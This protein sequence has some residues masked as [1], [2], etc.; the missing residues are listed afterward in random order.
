ME[1][2]LEDVVNIYEGKYK[3]CAEAIQRRHKDIL[4]NIW[5]NGRDLATIRDE[6]KPLKLWCLWQEQVLGMN[7]KTVNN[8]IAVFQADPECKMVTHY[9]GQIHVL[10][11]LV[12]KPQPGLE[13]KAESIRHRAR[14]GEKMK[15]EDIN[16]ILDLHRVE[17]P[18]IR[19]AVHTANEVSPQTIRDIVITG[20]L[21]DLDGNDVP[22][23]EADVTLIRWNAEAEQTDRIFQHKNTELLP[24]YVVASVMRDNHLIVTFENPPADVLEWFAKVNKA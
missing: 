10:Y 7:R 20:A 5:T 23:D 19:A 15:P 11:D 14:R 4:L 22:L 16:V 9:E 6:L 18:K 13:I 24:V 21:P 17:E 8:Y 2:T 3:I 1:T 12:R